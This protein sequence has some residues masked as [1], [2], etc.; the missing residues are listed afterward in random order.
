MG[1]ENIP[2]AFALS[3]NSCWV[4]V[5]RAEPTQTQTEMDT[6]GQ[7]ALWGIQSISSMRKSINEAEPLLAD[8]LA[9]YLSRV[10]Q[11]KGSLLTAD[12]RP[13]LQNHYCSCN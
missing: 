13:R 8:G 5:Q 2:S 7:S 3:Q 4:G 1:T 12:A 6:Q 11:N 10:Q 9:W